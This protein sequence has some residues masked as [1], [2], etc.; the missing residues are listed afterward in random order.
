VVGLALAL[1]APRAAAEAAPGAPPAEI[2]AAA[3]ANR[4]DLDFTA[5]IELVMRDASGAERRRRFRA[6]TKVIGQRLHS[7]G[8]LVWPADL[9]GM[10]IL[11]IEASGRGH[12]AFLYLPSLARVRR[13]TLAQR[14]DSFLGSDVTFEDL[15]RRR[16]EEYEIVAAR[17]AAVAGEP[18][19]AIEARPWAAARYERVE[20]RIARSD[21]SILE[22]RYYKRGRE[23]PFRVIEAPRAAIVRRA[24]HA[25]PTRLRVQDLD[26]G[27]GTEVLFSELVVDPPIDD[28]IFSVDTLATQRALPG[29][30]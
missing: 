26:R 25:I 6:V 27:T 14:G 1:A 23:R 11:T 16:L 3:F 29:E 8:R 20:F 28:R 30:R 5:S 2:L 19:Y 9:R 22:T 4:Y 15:E 12:D 7:I 21:L 17:G 18:V 24:G 13:I 10:T